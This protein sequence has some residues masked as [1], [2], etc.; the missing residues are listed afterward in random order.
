MPDQVLTE[1]QTDI[2][3][4]TLNR[5]AKLNSIGLEML[6]ALNEA[7]GQAETDSTVRVVV[8][9][10]AGAKAFSAGGN[11]QEFA[12][13]KGEAVS[14]WIEQGHAVFNRLAQLKKPT[15]AY[16]DGYALGGG[17]ELALTC[18]FRLGTERAVLGSPEVTNGW[19]PGWGGMV[20]LRR[21]VSE[22]T[23]KEIVLLGEKISA[24]RS[25]QMG[26][27]TRVLRQGHE[28]EEVN[29]FVNH[30]TNLDPAVYALA[31]AALED[32]PLTTGADVAFDIL[33][34]PTARS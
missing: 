32:N 12:A 28:A 26:L 30:L 17:L 16:I 8:I 6:S 18:D 23:A 25:L 5:P 3:R 24:S 4:I 22:A 10:G 7:L 9:E 15:V 14:H 20:R 34:V 21:L 11:T 29:E 19:L 1:Q 31:K 13:L 27:L 33:A 2:L